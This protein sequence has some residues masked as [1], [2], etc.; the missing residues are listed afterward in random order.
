[1]E[2]SQYDKPLMTSLII[3]VVAGIL[4]ISVAVGCTI[5]LVKNRHEEE[6][7]MF[8]TLLILIVGAVIGTGVLFVNVIPDIAYDLNN[9]AYV[10]VEGNFHVVYDNKTP[11]KGCSLILSNN[12]R[13][14]T[15]LYVF[16]QGEYT[17]RIVYGERTETVLDV[18]LF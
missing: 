12:K 5:Y 16:S 10:V 3:W 6:K 4:V 9:H 13:L 2:Y 8:I 17:G 15:T 14:E 18:Q 1:M 7:F 11:S